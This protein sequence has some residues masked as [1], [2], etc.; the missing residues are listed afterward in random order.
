MN[1]PKRIQ[2]RLH[3][4]LTTAFATAVLALAIAA[5]DAALAHAS[6]PTVL[7]AGSSSGSERREI[8]HAARVKPAESAIP[9]FE[10]ASAKLEANDQA[11][12]LGDRKPDSLERAGKSSPLIPVEH[13][14][15]VPDKG[16][17]FV[18]GLYL[19]ANVTFYDCAVQGFCEEMYNGRT[20]YEGAAACSWDLSIGTRFYIVGDP[21][22]RIY[23]CEDRGRLE[24]TWVDIFWHNPSDGRTW[25]NEV[26]RYAPIILI[27]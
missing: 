27:E 6:S 10:V 21:T 2:L 11:T 17:I 12:P 25:Q 1:N 7:G 18:K 26:G 16:N 14:M 4:V 23:V 24:N 13:R 19:N 5:S 15:T 3:Q 8:V 20:V 9:L 22:N